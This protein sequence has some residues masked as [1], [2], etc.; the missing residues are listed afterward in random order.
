MNI[1]KIKNYLGKYPRI[2]SFIKKIILSSPALRE[3]ISKKYGILRNPHYLSDN[4]ITTPL[5]NDFKHLSQR[6]A[7]IYKDIKCLREYK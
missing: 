5:Q 4:T 1:Q 6:G 3:Y 7:K 2:K